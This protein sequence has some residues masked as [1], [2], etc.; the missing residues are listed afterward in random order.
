MAA[1][2]SGPRR[3]RY[4]TPRDL[5][6]GITVVLSDGTVARAGGRV[7][8]NVAGYDLCK[9]F[10]GSLGTLG[11]IALLTFRLHPMPA[12][13]RVVEVDVT[14]SDTALVAARLLTSATLVPSAV[15]LS[16][17][18]EADA[19]TVSA[20]Y[21]GI[22]PGVEAQASRARSLLSHPSTRGIGAPRVS[23]A[24]DPHE[25]PTGS[26]SIKLAH[27]PAELAGAIGAARVSADRHGVGVA[28]S[29][30]A[31]TGVTSVRFRD[32]I[33]PSPIVAVLGELRAFAAEVGGSAVVLGAAPEVKRT[34]DVGVPRGTRSA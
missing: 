5:L 24:W 8:K 2:A 18:A 22:E 34:V 13:R 33:E 26:T 31:A 3:L 23:D 4:G 27:P 21:E 28:L 1:G 15:E 12:A 6:I 11:L 20:L 9:L 19:G 14:A 16:W 29:G 32:G 10:T 25:A 30:H 7:V 17:P